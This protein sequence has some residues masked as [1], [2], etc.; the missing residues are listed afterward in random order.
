MDIIV[1]SL[2]VKLYENQALPDSQRTVQY[3]VANGNKILG[4]SNAHIEFI[5]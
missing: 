5:N 3:P 2:R 1:I 4:K